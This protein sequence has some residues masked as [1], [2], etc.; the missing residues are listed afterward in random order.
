MLIDPDADLSIGIIPQGTDI[1]HSLLVWKIPLIVDD[2]M[3][4][5]L[6]RDFR[7]TPQNSFAAMDFLYAIDAIAVE[8]YRVSLIRTQRGKRPA[9][10][11]SN[12]RIEASHSRVFNP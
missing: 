3:K 4:I 2:L 9:H 6:R 12:R 11:S 5:F 1:L 7:R 8:G 10:P